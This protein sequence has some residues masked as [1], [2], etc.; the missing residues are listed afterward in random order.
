MQR[1][2]SI[3]TVCMLAL[4]LAGC[5]GSEQPAPTAAEPATA[6]VAAATAATRAGL[7]EDD[8]AF[9][10]TAA[11]DEAF[12][13]ALGR[14]AV[15]KASTDPMRTL[16]QRMV[17]DHT[18]MRDELASIAG[19]GGADQAPPAMPA[20]KALLMRNHLAPLQGDAFRNAF[21]D[22]TVRDYH[23]AIALFAAEAK[24]GHDKALRNFAR[25][26]LPALREHLAMVQAMLK[27]EGSP[28][29]A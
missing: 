16:A 8:Q 14:M 4:T 29:Q 17:D 18:R 22:V 3:A 15:E 10:A 21:V 23:L 12:Q 11:S 6:P 9:V 27:A 19:P 25:K 5:G 20:D 28:P 26:E 7:S 24:N 1:A 13:I 2:L